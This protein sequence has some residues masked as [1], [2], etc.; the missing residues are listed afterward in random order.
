MSQHSRAREEQGKGRQRPQ[1]G[2]QRL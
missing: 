2:L 1:P